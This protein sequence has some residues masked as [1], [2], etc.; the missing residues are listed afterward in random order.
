M[1]QHYS[2]GSR[3]SWGR[4]RRL[5]EA[6]L[7]LPA[8]LVLL[9]GRRCNTGAFSERRFCSI[10]TSMRDS[11]VGATGRLFQPDPAGS[12]AEGYPAAM[13]G[14]DY[15]V[16]QTS[17]GSTVTSTASGFGHRAMVVA[18]I[19]VRV[20]KVPLDQVINMVAMRNRLVSTLRPM[21]MIR[22]MPRAIVPGRAV[23]RIRRV[24]A[25]NMFI[26]M[27]F[28]RI[29][30][31]AVMQVVDVAI[32]HDSGMAA[33]QPMEMIMIFVLRRVTMAH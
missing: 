10:F 23:L 31:M 6:L 29:M 22:S 24:Y 12:T 3:C 33:F 25:N 19:I 9:V 28:M 13:P 14:L 16:G 11:G 5:A 8:L 26:D 20:V 27:V 32:V 7:V 4:I 15:R 1:H 2:F 30:Q 18:M 21:H 17:R